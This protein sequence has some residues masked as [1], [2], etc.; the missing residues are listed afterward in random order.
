MVG[1]CVT[2]TYL[3]CSTVMSLQQGNDQDKEDEALSSEEPQPSTSKRSTRGTS[4]K[5]GGSPKASGRSVVQTRSSGKSPSGN[6]FEKLGEDRAIGPSKIA[7]LR[8]QGKSS[9]ATEAAQKLIHSLR[10]GV[11][12]KRKQPLSKREWKKPFLSGPRPANMNKRLTAIWGGKKRRR[13]SLPANVKDEYEQ[14]RRGGK[15]EE[16]EDEEDSEE[17]SEE[18]EEE[19]EGKKQR[20][21]MDQDT[22]QEVI[23]YMVEQEQETNPKALVIAPNDGY[24]DGNQQNTNDADL[25]ELG[26]QPG[27][28]KSKNKQKRQRPIYMPDPDVEDRQLAELEKFLQGDQNQPPADQYDEDDEEPQIQIEQLGGSTIIIVKPPEETRETPVNVKG[29]RGARSTPRQPLKKRW[30]AMHANESQESVYYEGAEPQMFRD[31]YDLDLA[32]D[33]IGIQKHIITPSKRRRTTA[34]PGSPRVKKR[35]P[36]DGDIECKYCEA[37]VKDYSYLYRHVRKMHSDE[38]DM[39]DYLDDLRPLMKTPCPVCDK[40][41]SSTGN[42]YTHIKN[43]HS[44]TIVAGY[45]CPACN[46]E[47]KSRSALTQHIR[48]EHAPKKFD[49]DLCDKSFPDQR[50]LREHNNAAHAE[51]SEAFQCDVCHKFYMSKCKLR[52]HRLIH[53]AFRHFCAYCNKGFHLKDNMNKHV[54]IVHESTESPQHQCPH[55]GKNFLV[56][57]NLTQHIRGVHLKQ[58]AFNCTRCNTGFH[59]VKSLQQHME[60]CTGEF[61]QG[62][63]AQQDVVQQPIITTE[64]GVEGQEPQMQ[65]VTIMQE[66]LEVDEVV[67]GEVVSSVQNTEEL[68]QEQALRIMEMA[69]DQ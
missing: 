54:R 55:C 33:G 3:F 14:A 43:C 2:I 17:E 38:V 23:D 41:F 65:E 48:T 68:S 62:E 13:Q 67:H 66:G 61:E 46:S 26:M 7:K 19:E 5:E 40:V 29:K 32:D 60:L 20:A 59:R 37:S 22:I 39:Q 56:K 69:V 6:I 4:K 47:F 15:H 45:E 35:V 16:E 28:K 42:V 49:C 24:E 34:F 25:I 53:G 8:Q 21:G 30:S 44:E 51:D 36:K 52:R 50:A 63:V 31:P 12:Q 57:G 27:R 9:P 64:E 18:E 1:K 11:I 58:F 10:R